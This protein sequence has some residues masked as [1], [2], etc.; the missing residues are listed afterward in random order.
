MHFVF[1]TKFCINYCFQI[2][3]RIDDNS[4]CKILWGKP[5]A[6]WVIWKSLIGVLTTPCCN[7]DDDGLEIRLCQITPSCL[8]ATVMLCDEEPKVVLSFFVVL[9]DDRSARL[10]NQDLITKIN[11]ETKKVI[12]ETKVIYYPPRMDTSPRSILEVNTRGRNLLLDT[13]LKGHLCLSKV[14]SPL[15]ES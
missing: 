12:L 2:H 9:I 6:L 14:D 4:L 10:S 1:P 13:S 15:E 5:N 7:D 3:L 11:R 8:T